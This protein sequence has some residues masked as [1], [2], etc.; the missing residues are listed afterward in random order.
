[1]KSIAIYLF[2]KPL[3]NLTILT[4]LI[5]ALFLINIG[6]RPF[7]APSESRY[8]EIGREMAESGDFV[9]PRLNYVKYFEKPPLFYWIQA[10][11][12]KYIGIDAFS[13]RLPTAFFTVLLC[14]ATY[15]LAMTLYN[16]KRTAW[17]S[18]FVLATT[19]Y[20]FSLSRI[21]LV[22]LPVSLF[23]V[24]TLTSFLYFIKY[25]ESRFRNIAIYLMYVFAALAVLSKGLIGAILPGA[26]IF[27]WLCFK[28]NWR[29]FI[30]DLLNRKMIPCYVFVG[31]YALPLW[32][33]VP[34]FILFL[35]FV[36]WFVSAENF[37]FLKKTKIIT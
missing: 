19:I 23:M 30:N 27:L 8:V 37:N 16:E 3:V 36:V 18:T 7:S 2:N 4:I 34:Y 6:A 22:D 33:L 17:L 32:S 26:V 21:V 14:L 15:F 9:T 13:A 35:I 1:M 12:T 28:C 31:M 29:S 20:T 25:P 24:L 10:L 5:S 11:N